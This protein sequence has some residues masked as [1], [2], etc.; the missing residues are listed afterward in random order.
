MAKKTMAMIGID[1][2]SSSIRGV[3]CT[4]LPDGGAAFSL[5]NSMEIRGDYSRD[6]GLASGLAELREKLGIGP[7]DQVGTV[8][9]G[10]QVYVV[11]M[12]FRKL[13]P[14]ETRKA[15]RLELRKSL[16]FDATTAAIEFQVLEGFDGKPDEQHLLVT[17]VANTIIAKHLE[18]MEKAG[19]KPA[20]V[21]TLPTCAANAFFAGNGGFA[22]EDAAHVVLHLGP[23]VCTLIVSGKTTPFFHR[24]IYFAAQEVFGQSGAD[25]PTDQERKRRVDS[26][27]EEVMRSI[28]Y[29]QKNNGGKSIRDL[30]LLGA[31]ADRPELTQVMADKTGLEV[32]V[33]DLSDHFADASAISTTEYALALTLAM[34]EN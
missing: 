34:R 1:Y 12:P 5:D 19:I 18:L 8:I 6:E 22:D 23:S 14:E 33:V 15:L 25:A 10:K 7:G 16:P 17:A 24:N 21:D 20:I 4:R 28:A 29:Y 2:D 32:F 9:S 13:K 26:L 3:R 31:N 30:H 11:Q 27:A